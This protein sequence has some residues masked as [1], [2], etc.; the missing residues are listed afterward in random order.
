MAVITVKKTGKQYEV[1][2]GIL[3]LHRWRRWLKEIEIVEFPDGGA[4][5]DTETSR[6]LFSEVWGSWQL[7]KQYFGGYHGGHGG[8]KVLR[9]IR[10][11][12]FPLGARAFVMDGGPIHLLDDERN[13]PM[14][15]SNE[16]AT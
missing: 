8:S 14:E 6:Y 9:R 4:R 1:R 16:Q 13:E 2:S 5:V 7:A 3:W 15:T 12:F 10:R 11:V